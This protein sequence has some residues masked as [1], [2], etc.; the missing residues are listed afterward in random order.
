MTQAFDNPIGESVVQAVPESVPVM[1]ACACAHCGLAVPKG[2]VVDHRDE[3]FCCHACES[4]YDVIHGC[5]LDAYYRLRKQSEKSRKRARSADHERLAVFDSPNFHDR[6]VRASGD[7]MMTCDL[8]LQGVHCAACVWLIEKL[9]RV[10]PGVIDA[11]LS[12]REA[13]VRVVWDAETLNLSDI[14]KALSNLGYT[15][16]PARASDRQAAHLAEQRAML[17]RLGVA[18]ALAGN[19]MLL[20]FA[21]YTGMFSGMETQFAELFRWVSAAL[22]VLALAWPGR[23]FFRGAFAAIRTRSPHLDLPIALALGAGGLAGTVNVVLGRGDIY[24]DS[25]TVLVFLLLAGRF[26]QYRQHRRADDAVGLL[27]SLTPTNC[28]RVIAGEHANEE[29]ETEQVPIEAVAVGDCLEVH[30]GE[31]I[32]ADGVI[33]QGQASV[34]AA[35]L[36]GESRPEIVGP[37]DSVYAGA[38]LSDATIRFRVTA[39]GDASRVGKLMSLVQQGMTDKPPAVAL[40]DRVAGWFV[41][42]VSRLALCVFSVW[43]MFD[44]ALAVDH[45]VA[46]LIIACP[47]ALGLA[48][49]LGMAVAIGR[50]AKRDILIKSATA[51]DRLSR[52]GI[53]LI[54]KTGTVTRGEMRIADWNGD[55]SL[56]PILADVERHATHPIARAIVQA[57]GHEDR[58]AGRRIATHAIKI[59]RD[60]VS[61]QTARGDLRVGSLGYIA[62][63]GIKISDDRRRLAEAW[64]S[65][66]CTTIY[67]ALA[68]AI[69][70]QIAIGD[71]VHDDAGDALFML[72]QW[73]WQVH[74]LTG[75]DTAVAHQVG[76]AIG[77]KPKQID[78]GVSPEGKL[79]AVKHHAQGKRS[80]V[81]IGDG[82]ND[83]AALAAA[84]VGIAVRGGAEA[85]LAAA[86]VYL[87]QPGLAG[88][89]DLIDTSRKSQRVVRR[90]LAISF[91]YNAVGIGLAAAGLVNPLVAAVL[92]PVSSALVLVL[93]MQGQAKPTIRSCTRTESR[94]K[95]GA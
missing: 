46:L 74:M 44:I 81:M 35:L 75:D 70:A 40:T 61:A 65:R 77:L 95:G 15:P 72:Q 9:P 89:V 14:A 60:G 92:M 8:M 28:R 78:A 76:T 50:A 82:V 23:V 38:Q 4:A 86:D 37:S 87:V 12:L 56:Q 6:Y 53:L 84:D 62:C 33:E 90:N 21:L 19:T 25:L 20:A 30:S 18:G 94:S 32:P 2:L 83:A 48:T 39:T 57:Y 24:F 59:E 58:P 10:L 67:V 64:S 7:G 43:S 79:D 26:I 22:G 73:G 69:A 17:V 27:L 31:L 13:T 41:C 11:R 16:H 47:C 91:A 34:I 3:Q 52:P 93:A 49:P 1:K 45:T 36:T 88:L 85:S 71:A 42:I 51:L 63:Q 80:V 29:S 5:G 68:G 55:A 66:G 54:D